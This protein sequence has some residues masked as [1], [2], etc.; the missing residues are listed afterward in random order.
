MDKKQRQFHHAAQ[1]GW[2][3]T[4]AVKPFQAVIPPEFGG[5]FHGAGENI[6]ASAQAAEQVRAGFRAILCHPEF[7]FRRA[8]AD[9]YHICAACTDGFDNGGVV[10][11]VAVVGSG[12]FKAEIAFFQDFS[13]SVRNAGLRAQERERPCFAIRAMSP[14]ANSMPG[15]GPGGGCRAW[16]RL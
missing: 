12:D 10:L 4:Q 1:A 16:L 11:E 14:A 3:F 9:E 8:Q 15:A 13:G 5:A 7:L 6:Q 2:F